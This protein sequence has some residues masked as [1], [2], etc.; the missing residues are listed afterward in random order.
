MDKPLQIAFKDLDSSAYLEGIIRERVSRLERFHNHITGCR[1]VVEIPHRS[2]KSAKQPI[3]IAV[4]VEVPGRSTVVA[5]DE[6]N[7]HDAKND[8]TVVINR[9][10]DAVQR[11]LEDVSAI[12]RGDV[13]THEGTYE[14]GLVV[15]LFPDQNYGFIEVKGAPD[16]Y[17]TRNAV[18]GGNFD[19]ISIGTIVQV[20]RATTEGPMGPQASSV[21]LLNARRSPT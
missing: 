4:E 13:K 17:F 19:D 20:T 5:K 3:A 16:L 2:A 6:E 15:R 18:T 12:Q 7:R 14:T 21:R 10:F 1:V 11:Q 8:Q 9:V